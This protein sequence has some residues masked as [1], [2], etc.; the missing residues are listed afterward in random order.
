MQFFAGLRD[1]KV[2]LEKP[3]ESRCVADRDEN[4]SNLVDDLDRQVNA[5]IECLGHGAD[6]LFRNKCVQCGF[7]RTPSFA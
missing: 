2:L 7:Q 4:L 6:S 5:C 1:R 3:A